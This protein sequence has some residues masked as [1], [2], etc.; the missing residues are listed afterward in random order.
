M[1]HWMLSHTDRFRVAI[2]ENGI[3]N[4][5]SEFGTSGGSQASWTWNLGGT[6]WTAPERYRDLSP[7]T[8]VAD[9]RTPLLL[10]HAEND[11]NCPIGQSE[12]MFTALAL[13]GREVALVRVPGEGH[14]MNL[15]GKPSRRLARL[16][17]INAWLARYLGV[18]GEE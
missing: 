9:I 10:I 5:V 8:Y 12:E 11:H 3:S 18:V 4:L 17:A 16:E 15:V 6:P 2:S 7:L 1:T 14:L 13:L